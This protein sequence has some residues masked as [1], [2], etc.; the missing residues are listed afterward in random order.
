MRRLLL[1][2]TPLALL[3][4]LFLAIGC[5][6]RG[7]ARYEVSGTVTLG[8]EM[9]DEGI[10][11]FIPMENQGSKTGARIVNGEYQVP[12]DK[13]LMVGKYKVSI[14]AGDGSQTSGKGEPGAAKPGFVPG[15]ERIP[16]EYNEKSDKVVEIKE[17]GPN[18][19]DYTIPKRK[20]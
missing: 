7:P 18:R 19:F 8:G 4:G 6:P 14:V 10:I 16:P 13:G 15:G 1:G 9:L 11:D 17:E 5:G 3:A 2:S 20:A 12:K